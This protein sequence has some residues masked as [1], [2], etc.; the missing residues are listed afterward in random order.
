MRDFTEFQE[1]RARASN[2]PAWKAACARYHKA[3]K[4]SQEERDA[5]RAMN[6]AAGKLNY[7]NLG[8]RVR[9]RAIKDEMRRRDNG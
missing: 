5:F 7:P 3:P 9:E 6:E 1:L 8:K 4:G 2:D